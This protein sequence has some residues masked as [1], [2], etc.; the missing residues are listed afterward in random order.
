[1]EAWAVLG[2]LPTVV[3]IPR[4][5]TVLGLP[6][7]CGPSWLRMTVVAAMYHQKFLFLCLLVYLQGPIFASSWTLCTSVL[8]PSVLPRGVRELS[9]NMEETGT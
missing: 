7:S 2:R 4:L 8:I 5:P 1:M 6:S 3:L 9:T